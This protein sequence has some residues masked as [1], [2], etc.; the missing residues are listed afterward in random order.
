MTSSFNYTHPR[1]YQP[2]FLKGRS[3]SNSLGY[4][5]KSGVPVAVQQ[6]LTKLDN[7][8]HEI[9][10]L[11]DAYREKVV[12]DAQLQWGEVANSIQIT[13]D[14]DTRK[15]LVYSDDPIA[16]IL[17]HGTDEFAPAP[18]IRMAAVR[19]EHELAPKISKLFG[20]IGDKNA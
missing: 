6:V 3:H 12:K 11:V 15:L 14:I 4:G 1:S 2:N 8:K 10:K 20:Q 9:D 5:N 19:A 13:F 7:L 17:E 16:D 18:V